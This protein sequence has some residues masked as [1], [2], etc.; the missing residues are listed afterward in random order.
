MFWENAKVPESL[1]TSLSNAPVL[2]VTKEEEKLISQKDGDISLNCNNCSNDDLKSWLRKFDD[3]PV[4]KFDSLYGNIAPNFTQ[5]EAF[6]CS[7][8]AQWEVEV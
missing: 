6:K 1:H 7:T 2:S 5:E 4:I 3:F 8:Y